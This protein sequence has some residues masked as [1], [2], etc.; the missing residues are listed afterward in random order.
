MK[1]SIFKN[2]TAPIHLLTCFGLKFRRTVFEK[3]TLP[4]KKYLGR[5]NFCAFLHAYKKFNY[6]KVLVLFF[7]KALSI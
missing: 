6:V 5:I 2:T 4:R 7:F 3:T 1:S